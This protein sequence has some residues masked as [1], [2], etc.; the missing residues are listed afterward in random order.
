MAAAFEWPADFWS[1]N[2]TARLYIDAANADQRRELEAIFGGQKGG[3][4]AA[5]LSAVVSNVLPT[6]DTKIDI[7]WGDNPSIS[8]GSVG[9]VKLQ[10][11]KDPAGRPTSVQGAAAMAAFQLESMDLASSKGSRWSDS[12]LRPWQ[13]DSGTIHNFNWSA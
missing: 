1:G 5:V 11:L 2:G 12:E 7:Q 13:G 8:V 3:H 10:R 4:L 9:Q 6:Q